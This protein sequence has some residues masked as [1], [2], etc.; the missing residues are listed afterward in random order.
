MDYAKEYD[1]MVEQSNKQ[2]E[3]IAAQAAVIEKLRES[4][5]KLTFEPV[6][7]S[8][9]NTADCALTTKHAL[10]GC[11]RS[12]A[13]TASRTARQNQNVESGRERRDCA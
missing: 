5:F 2:Q 9:F 7:P 13:N 1:R 4:L 8:D 12:R 3:T 10:A 11:T 6:T